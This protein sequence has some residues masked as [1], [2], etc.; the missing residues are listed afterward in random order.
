M[1]SLPVGRVLVV[2]DN[3]DLALLFA[4][5]I[6]MM[7]YETHTV[8][9][10]TAALEVLLEFSPHVVFSD[11]DMPTSSGFDLARS[12]RA[13]ALPQPFLVSVSSWY[14][15][16]TVYVSC[17]SGFDLHLRKPVS[18]DQISLLLMNYFQGIGIAPAPQGLDKDLP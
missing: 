3:E 5:L 2:D 12:I 9:S 15:E 8:F 4:T 13:S 1:I 14:D 7:G 17:R 18:Y 16:Q 11:I 10:V 6:G